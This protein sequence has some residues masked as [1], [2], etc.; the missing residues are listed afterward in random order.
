MFANE[1]QKDKW[2]GVNEAPEKPCQ[3]RAGKLSLDF[4][5]GRLTNISM[6]GKNVID[7]V[8]FALRDYNWGTI[9]Y[10]MENLV[11]TQQAEAFEV[12]FTAVHEKDNIQF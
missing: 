6:G 12:S 2:I 1:I 4:V 5:S 10:R 3:L 9:P 7:E 11:I 8:Y